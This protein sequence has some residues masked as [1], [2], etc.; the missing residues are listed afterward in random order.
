MAGELPLMSAE[1]NSLEGARQV[2][3]TTTIDGDAPLG[4]NFRLS[5]QGSITDLI[6][7]S[8]SPNCY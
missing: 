1:T 3:S 6:D 2:D 5:F 8:L 7:T 4:A